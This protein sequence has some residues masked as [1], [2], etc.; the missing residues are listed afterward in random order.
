MRADFAPSG[1]PA[2]PIH[3]VTGETYSARLADL[4]A[5]AGAAARMQG[6]EAKPGQHML[7][8]GP[9]GALTAVVFALEAAAARAR[10]PFLPGKLATLLPEGAYRFA[11]PPGDPALAALGWLLASYRFTRYKPAPRLPALLIAPEGVDRERL[12]AI[13]AGVEL[14]RDLVNT[15]AD[16]KSVV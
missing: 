12:R 3:F 4:P 8:G 11:A 5:L 1:A 13:A 9:D 16:R 2:V 6:F 7:V 10:D 15:P 14:G